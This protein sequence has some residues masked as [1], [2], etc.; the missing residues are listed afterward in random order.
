MYAAPRPFWVNPE[1][2]GERCPVGFGNPG[3]N[4]LYSMGGTLLLWL[5]YNSHC[6]SREEPKWYHS[7]GIRF[8]LLAIGFVATSLVGYALMFA[9]VHSLDQV[10]YA[11]QLGIWLAF[12]FHFLIRDTLCSYIQKLI[13]NSDTIPWGKM[14]LGGFGIA[15]FLAGILIGEYFIVTKLER[16]GDDEE[17]VWVENMIAGGTCKTSWLDP[18]HMFTN[19]YVKFIGQIG[20]P[21]GAYLGAL[22]T[23]QF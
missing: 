9:G 16:P 11:I 22:L 10:L 20:L 1:I 5:D 12:T 4:A 2:H 8:V 18:N 13:H 7:L 15:L 23:S 3:S 19:S 17:S 14:A 21:L 6:L